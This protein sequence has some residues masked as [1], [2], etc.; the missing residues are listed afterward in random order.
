MSTLELKLPSQVIQSQIQE[1]SDLVAV[2]L[3]AVDQ[4]DITELKIP[5]T[6]MQ[7]GSPE[8][9][10]DIESVIT[11]YRSWVLSNGLRDCVDSLSIAFEWAR[12]FCFLWSMPGDIVSHPDGR[13]Q[14]RGISTGEEWN[15]QIS[16]GKKFEW[17]P[18]KKK[19]EYLEEHYD[20][21]V[22]IVWSHILS[23]NNARNC[24]THRGGVVGAPD[25]KDPASQSFEMKWIRLKLDVTTSGSSLEMN[26]S[27]RVNAGDIVA[28]SSVETKKAYSI[29]D[30]LTF[31]PAEVVEIMTTFGFFSQQFEQAVIEVQDRRIK[32]AQENGKIVIANPQDK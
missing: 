30:R 22:P 26:K 20:I 3:Q 24:L 1:I 7:I 19:M 23:I 31:S 4:A 21:S 5:D 16:E 8:E 18:L 27:M 15:H 6:F 11:E 32:E 25:L 14:M 10:R 28:V 13:Y 12:R 2:G 9:E 17:F 29:G